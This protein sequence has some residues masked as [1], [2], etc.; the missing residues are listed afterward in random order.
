MDQHIYA[1][2]KHAL[3]IFNTGSKKLSTRTYIQSACGN[4][5]HLW[6][7]QTSKGHGI[8]IHALDD[9]FRT[10]ESIGS[11][12]PKRE[13]YR[14]TLRQYK[15]N[16]DISF[17]IVYDRC[18]IHL[19]HFVTGNLHMATLTNSLDQDNMPKNAT[20]YQDPLI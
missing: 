6:L 1:D 7:S 3:W 4:S 17:T 10:T 16:V 2:Q 13:I 9:D 18:D 8:C 20:F 19:H 12:S 14:I 15:A 5:G 11:T